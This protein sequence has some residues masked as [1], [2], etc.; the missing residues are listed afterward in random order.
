MNVS[1][2]IL[3][4]NEELNLERCLASLE[5][6][7]DV[8]VLDSKSK[9]RTLE[10]AEK[11]GARVVERSFDNYANQRNYGLQEI[12]YKY[13]WL[14]MVDADEVVTPELIVE[15]E[16]T[17]KNVTS[18]LCIFRMR[19]K[20][21]FMGQW[22]RRSSGYPTWF[23][24]LV[25][26]GTVRVERSINEEYVTD[27]EVGLLSEHLLH[28]PFNK[29]FHAWIEKHNKYSTMEAELLEI[30]QSDKIL[31]M[32]VFSADPVSRRKTIKQLVYRM[33]G[34]PFL[35]FC[36][37]YIIRGGFLD[38]KAGLMFCLLRSFYEFMIVCKVVEAK[39]RQ[40]GLAL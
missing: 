11:L 33:P 14:L 15:I 38:G 6:C 27:G 23:G 3:T 29:G 5:W 8:V 7:D 34:R 36:A 37:L 17:L 2:L 31:L 32:N 40:K 39:I 30:K 25:K 22:I 24:R 28:Y 12:A 16:E 13:P 35:M 20:D 1:V 9:D 4:L 26:I 18:E 10:I 21:F 19:R